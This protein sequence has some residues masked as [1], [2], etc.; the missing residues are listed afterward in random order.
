MPRTVQK[1][2][3]I[4]RHPALDYDKVEPVRA[5]PFFIDNSRN[6]K[7]EICNDESTGL[8]LHG[9][10]LKLSQGFDNTMKENFQYRLFLPEAASL[11]KK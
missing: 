4:Y 2:A 5:S 11:K 6:D 10:L 8:N 9:L 1:G 3:R 7:S